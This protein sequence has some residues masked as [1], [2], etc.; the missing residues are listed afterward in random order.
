ME[1]K[2]GACRSG[3]FAPE[4]GSMCAISG[5]VKSCTTWSR[6]RT[7]C[8]TSRAI[9]RTSAPGP[10]SPR[11]SIASSAG[12]TTRFQAS[13]PRTARVGL[14]AQWR[15]ESGLNYPGLVRPP[16]SVSALRL[17]AARG[18]GELKLHAP[19]VVQHLGEVEVDAGQVCG[20]LRSL[21]RD[22]V[23]G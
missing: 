19:L 15:N 5:T 16:V 22:V 20:R 21:P 17:V 23:Q 8:E 6:T 9:P 14:S 1:S 3:W 7:R 18:A 4:P 11:S 10:S 2:A 13:L 12:A